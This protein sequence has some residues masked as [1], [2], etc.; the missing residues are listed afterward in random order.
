VEVESR[1][2]EEEEESA[3]IAERLGAWRPPEELVPHRRHFSFAIG[4]I[5]P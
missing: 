4:N 1:E 3:S 5:L 2:E